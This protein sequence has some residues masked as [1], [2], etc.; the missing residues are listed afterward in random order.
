L[1]SA[2]P[3]NVSGLHRSGTT[4]PVPGRWPPREAGLGA[5]LD[6]GITLA[7]LTDGGWEKVVQTAPGHVEAVR[8]LVFD[9]LTKAQSRQLSDIGQRIMRAIDPQDRCLRSA[10]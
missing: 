2:N 1:P 5:A 8:T 10:D 4:P 6:G 3:W 7:T 9:P